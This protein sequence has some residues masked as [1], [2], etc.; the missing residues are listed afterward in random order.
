M[1]MDLAQIK[2]E[3][4]GMGY[5]IPTF[6]NPTPSFY[7]LEDGTIMAV[8]I[9]LLHL[10]PNPRNQSQPLTNSTTECLTFTRNRKPLSELKEAVSPAIK[11]ENVP[12]DVLMENFNAYKLSNGVTVNVKTVLGQ[13]NQVEGQIPDGGAAYTITATPVVNIDSANQSYR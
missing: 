11:R 2:K 13:V 1:L 7:R 12:F 9:R 5:I 3:I 6:E 8:L 10:S 4:T